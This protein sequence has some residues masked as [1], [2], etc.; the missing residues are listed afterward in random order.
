MSEAGS[1]QTTELP[2]STAEVGRR[3]I[4]MR[5]KQVMEA[6]HLQPAEFAARNGWSLSA[7]YSYFRG[8][9]SPRADELRVLVNDGVDLAWLLTG[10]EIK[11]AHSGDNINA[12]TVNVLDE[13]V[14]VPRYDVRVSAGHGTLVHS[15]QVV[16][17]LAFK[18]DWV[19]DRLRVRPDALALVQVVGDSMEP[20]L[21]DGDL[22]LVHLAEQ[23]LKDG[24]AYVIE[25]GGELRVKRIA[26]RLDGSV[27][28]KSD[29]PRYGDEEVSEEAAEHL[30]VLGQVIWHGGPL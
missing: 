18:R 21:S 10:V 8:Q 4:G 11:P 27:L 12:P 7:L 6:R 5:L 30:R 14:L 15:D 19:V 26:R 9:T 23:R 29:N 1:G 24:A 17:H 20:T 22:A 28:V 13:F 25:V 2:T 16:D 3:E